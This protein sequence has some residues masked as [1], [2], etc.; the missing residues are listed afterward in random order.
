MTGFRGARLLRCGD[1]DE[2]M[3]TSITVFTG[4]DAVIS[5]AGADYQWAVVE[6]AA[7]L[8]L[9]RWD[10]RVTHHE[11]AVDLLP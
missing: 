3:F 4:L 6:E 5:F 2:V 10:H 11:I 9:T 8:V 1:L 7:R